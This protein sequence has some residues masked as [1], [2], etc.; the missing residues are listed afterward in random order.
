MVPHCLNGAPNVHVKGWLALADQDTEIGSKIKV[1][2]SPIQ[3]ILTNV[4]SNGENFG[5]LPQQ[6]QPGSE[7]CRIPRGK[8]ANRADWHSSAASQLKGG[9][10]AARKAIFVETSCLE[11]LLLSFTSPIPDHRQ[12]EQDSGIKRA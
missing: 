8:I 11:P 4:K 9:K 7:F 2:R 5:D 3:L 6:L 12:D 10:R 1:L